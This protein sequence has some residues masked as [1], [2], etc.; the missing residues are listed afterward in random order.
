MLKAKNNEPT[1]CELIIDYI[2][3]HGSITQK[4]AD[5]AFGVTRLP[6]RINNLKTQGYII[7][8]RYIKVKNRFGQPR[9]VKQYSFTPFE[10]TGESNG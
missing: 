6:S 8:S 9:N 1:Q 3:K 2:Q 5:R 7:Y 10:S 4:E